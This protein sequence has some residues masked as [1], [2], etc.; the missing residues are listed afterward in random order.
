M[1]DKELNIEQINA[2]LTSLEHIM[3]DAIVKIQTIRSQM[4]TASL[5]EKSNS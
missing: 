5:I 4:T 3:L 2:N 1:S